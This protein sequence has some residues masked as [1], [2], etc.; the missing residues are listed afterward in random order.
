MQLIAIDVITVNAVIALDA[1]RTYNFND[2]TY[3]LTISGL[4]LINCVDMRLCVFSLSRSPVYMTLNKLSYS[5]LFCLIWLS[6]KEQCGVH[7]C[8]MG[9]TD[10][11]WHS[12][13]SARRPR[14]CPRLDF[15]RHMWVEFVGSRLALRVFL[16]VLRFF[17]APQKSTLQ[18]PTRPG[19]G[20]CMKT[21]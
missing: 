21:R 19:Y 6:E 1:I 2:H 4:D 9:D 10:K 5:I 20:I 15:G 12:G 3:S 16:R 7:D 13:E 8:K 11:G 14:M 17:F 18:I